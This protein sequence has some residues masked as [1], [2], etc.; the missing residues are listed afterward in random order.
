MREGRINAHDLM[1]HHKDRDRA[2]NSAR[3]LE[4]ICRTHHEQEHKSERWGR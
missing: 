3:N 1:V 2:N 4:T